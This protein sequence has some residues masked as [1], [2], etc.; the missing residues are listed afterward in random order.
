M[1]SPVSKMTLKYA[2]Y[3]HDAEM[4][5]FILTHLCQ[6]GGHQIRNSVNLHSIVLSGKSRQDFFESLPG[7][8]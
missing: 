2:N 5:N 1:K 6:I 8:R 3:I 4:E 7:T